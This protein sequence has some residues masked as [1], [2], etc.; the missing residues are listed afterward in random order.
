MLKKKRER[1]DVK[2]SDQEPEWYSVCLC[3][4]FCDQRAKKGIHIT[5]F[6]VCIMHS[7]HIALIHSDSFFPNATFPW[8]SI[9]FSFFPPSWY[10]SIRM[11]AVKR[12]AF[13]CTQTVVAHFVVSLK[14]F[15]YVP[16]LCLYQSAAKILMK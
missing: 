8:L 12:I 9:L 1:K 13:M 10:S 15:S 3:M 4:C 7:R 2:N 5:H 6:T 14:K 16:V 11:N